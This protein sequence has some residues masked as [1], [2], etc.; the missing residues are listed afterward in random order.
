MTTDIGGSKGS[1][2]DAADEEDDSSQD[3]NSHDDGTD[4]NQGNGGSSS[5]DSRP[6]DKGNG[7]SS[8]GTA[9]EGDFDDGGDSR[10]TD[11]GNGGSSKGTAAEGDFDDG[12]DYGQ[13]RGYNHVKLYRLR[14]YQEQKADFEFACYLKERRAAQLKNLE[15][16]AVHQ[17]TDTEPEGIMFT[18]TTDERESDTRDRFFTEIVN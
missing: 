13:D 9:A 12:G 17:V 1:D 6:T 10:H 2:G 7:G 3:G 16:G 15:I 5:N 4:L 18:I 8:K 14:Q 11:K